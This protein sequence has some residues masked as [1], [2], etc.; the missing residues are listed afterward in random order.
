VA[1]VTLQVM[2]A[3][4]GPADLQRCAVYTTTAKFNTATSYSYY[5]YAGTEAQLEATEV[6]ARDITSQFEINLAG[7]VQA[8][9]YPAYNMP[10]ATTFVLVKYPTNDVKFANPYGVTRCGLGSSG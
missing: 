9:P 4:T 1:H 5:S 8:G 7:S 3:C 2:R 10:A 6:G